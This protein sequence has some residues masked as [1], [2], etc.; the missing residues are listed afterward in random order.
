[1][2]KEGVVIYNEILLSHKRVKFSLY[3]YHTFFIH[4]T[5]QISGFFFPDIYT[6]VELLGHMVLL[7][8]V[9]LRNCHT[10][11]QRDCTSLHFHQQYTRVFFFPHP[12]QNLLCS[13][14][15]IAILIGVTRYL[16]VII[17]GM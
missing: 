2:D 16:I 13:F 6:G 17:W 7:F 12:H 8:L 1:M 11:F 4:L 15:I 14:L 5:F 9:I 3:I 10:V